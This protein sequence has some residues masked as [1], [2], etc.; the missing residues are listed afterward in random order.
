MIRITAKEKKMAKEVVSEE[1]AKRFSIKCTLGRAEDMDGEVTGHE[2]ETEAGQM[3][4]G[5]KNFISAM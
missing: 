4:C 1:E 2:A 5:L 3:L